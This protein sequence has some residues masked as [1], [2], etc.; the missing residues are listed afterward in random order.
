[1]VE[2]VKELK[3]LSGSH[4]Q[5]KRDGDWFFVEKKYNTD[6]NLERYKE[7]SGN[8][9]RVPEIYSTGDDIYTMEYIPGT[10]MKEY[11]LYNSVRVFTSYF[12]S[13]MNQ[14]SENTIPKDYTE[15]YEKKLRGI[16]FTQFPFTMVELVDRLPPIL[17]SGL[18]HGDMTLDNIIFN[19]KRMEFVLVDPLTSDYDSYVFDIA[20]F[21]QDIRCGWFMRNEKTNLSSILQT[22]YDDVY[23]DFPIISNNELL[24]LMLLRVFP[25][26]RSE[27]DKM[28]IKREVNKLWT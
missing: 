23:K 24:I 14:F 13:L 18:Y 26:C 7:L 20:K 4:V 9:I 25:Y 3:G 16:D 1:M 17:P 10:L 28:F 21:G 6:R 11:F 27:A 5:L 22:I 12:C 15:V 19:D 8:G 2:V